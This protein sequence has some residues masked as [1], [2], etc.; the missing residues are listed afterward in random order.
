MEPRRRRFTLGGPPFQT[1]GLAQ[2]QGETCCP[3][4][5]RAGRKFSLSGVCERSEA[6]EPSQS[7]TVP[8]A[9]P[10]QEEVSFRGRAHLPTFLGRHTTP[11]RDSLSSALSRPVSFG[12]FQELRTSAYA[13]SLHSITSFTSAP[14]LPRRSSS[15]GQVPQSQ[16]SRGSSVGSRRALREL[17]SA[18]AQKLYIDVDKRPEVDLIFPDSSTL[19]STP[20][21]RQVGDTTRS[22]ELPP[23]AGPPLV[24]RSPSAGELHHKQ[25]KQAAFVPAFIVRPESKEARWSKRRQET[26]FAEFDSFGTGHARNER[27]HSA[28]VEVF[29]EDV[30][31]F[32]AANPRSRRRGLPGSHS[33][34]SDVAEPS[35]SA[36]HEQLQQQRPLLVY[37]HNLA[38][39]GS[40]PW[41]ESVISG[42]AVDNLMTAAMRG[43]GQL[44]GMMIK[45][46]EGVAG[47]DGPRIEQIGDGVMRGGVI[48]T[49]ATVTTRRGW[50]EGE[51]IEREGQDEV[52]G[53]GEEESPVREQE[54]VHGGKDEAKAQEKATG[55]RE[56]KEEEKSREGEEGKGKAM[57][58][59]E[60]EGNEEGKEKG[61]GNNARKDRGRKGERKMRGKGKSREQG[62]DTKEE[63]NEEME[64]DE[65]GEEAEPE[66]VDEEEY[67][68]RTPRAAQLEGTEAE[69]GP[70][71]EEYIIRTPVA[72]QSAGGAEPGSVDDEEN[73]SSTPV[74][75]QSEEEEAEPGP[76]D[77]EQYTIRTPV[78]AQSEGEATPPPDR[79]EMELCDADAE[80]EAAPLRDML[81]H[82]SHHRDALQHEGDHRAGRGEGARPRGPRGVLERF[83]AWMRRNL[84]RDNDQP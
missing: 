8:D 65:Q 73:I 51:V 38:Y 28:F 24:Y 37:E 17:E 69:P 19:Q 49:T 77:E 25:R 3:S 6:D 12:S 54:V 79:E 84:R 63:V 30:A 23:I 10:A 11:S 22:S 83:S 5:R 18:N 75:A 61:K 1:P 70:L 58:R 21:K 81:V 48:V 72:A 68:I 36:E 60:E 53:E 41:H 7:T 13:A 66:P 67:I 57:E 47:E 2:T 40:R 31:A 74:A 62:E 26:D 32:I 55:Q 71:D 43:D 59:E 76:V 27:A 29:D 78:A 42:A 64:D 20:R 15:L 50:E 9:T 44:S 39:P 33:F 52:E 45:A 4:R 35:R 56:R 16:G 46:T 80:I 14:P 34:A 82:G